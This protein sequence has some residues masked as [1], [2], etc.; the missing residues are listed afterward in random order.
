VTAVNALLGLAGA[1]AAFR[2]LRP[3]AAMRGALAAARA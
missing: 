2:T 1:M 3:L